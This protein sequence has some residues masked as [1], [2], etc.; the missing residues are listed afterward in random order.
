MLMTKNKRLVANLNFAFFIGKIAI[1]WISIKLQLFFFIKRRHIKNVFTSCTSF[2]NWWFLFL[3]LN[4]VGNLFFYISSWGYQ[5]T[6]STLKVSIQAL[7][8]N[9][10]V[11]QPYR[12]PWGTARGG[13]RG[14]WRPVRD[15]QGVLTP[16]PTSRGQGWNTVACN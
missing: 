11:R 5:I 2:Q 3:N 10:P 8:I 16:S 14:Q 6:G 1:L 12:G 15:G 4:P 7:F 9:V 13:Y